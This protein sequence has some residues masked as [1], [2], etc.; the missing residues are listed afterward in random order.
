MD[1]DRKKDKHP[2]VKAA[3]KE[4]FQAFAVGVKD[5]YTF[6]VDAA[7]KAFGDALGK[8]SHPDVKGANVHTAFT[9]A[10]TAATRARFESVAALLRA[11]DAFHAS[12]EDLNAALDAVPKA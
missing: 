2:V 3:V 10:V 11:A 5:D 9:P 4:F 6:D 7:M 8:S 12:G 1:K